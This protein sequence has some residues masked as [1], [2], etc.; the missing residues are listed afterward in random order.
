M[1]KYILVVDS[2][3]SWDDFSLFH[4]YLHVMHR[5]GNYYIYLGILFLT[6]PSMLPCDDEVHALHEQ[7]PLLMVPDPL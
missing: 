1:L 7:L 6:N 3:E 4:L 5:I 2:F